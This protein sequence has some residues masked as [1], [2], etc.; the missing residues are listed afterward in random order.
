MKAME[1][2]SLH[3]KNR[4]IDLK[5]LKDEGRKIVGHIP[6]GYLPEEIVLASGVI[7]NYL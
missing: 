2:L 1:K 4:L 6:G 5:G 7:P 3:L